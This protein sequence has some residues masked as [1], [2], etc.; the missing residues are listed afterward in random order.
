[1]TEARRRT[2][3]QGKE[4]SRPR[5]T[6][7]SGEMGLWDAWRGYLRHPPVSSGADYCKVPQRLAGGCVFVVWFPSWFGGNTCFP[8]LSVPILTNWETIASEICNR[9]KR[10]TGSPVLNAIASRDATWRLDDS[11]TWGNIKSSSR[12]VAKSSGAGSW[13]AESRAKRGVWR[14]RAP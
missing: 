12:Q 10:A 9:C 3:T 5:E 14:D 8:A 13:G 7:S 1:M 2:R 11:A 4:A 6:R